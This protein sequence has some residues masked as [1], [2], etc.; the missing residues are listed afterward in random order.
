M[1]AFEY[2]SN[3]KDIV[4]KLSINLVLMLVSRLDILESWIRI[5]AGL[6]GLVLTCFLIYKIY[7]DIK[8]NR[9]KL[10]K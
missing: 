10:G 6:F 1:S 4:G 5:S 9:K 2:I 3:N 7:L 8:I